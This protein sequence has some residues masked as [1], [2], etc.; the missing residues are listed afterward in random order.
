MITG[1]QVEKTTRR[2]APDLLIADSAKVVPVALGSKARLVTRRAPS[3]ATRVLAMAGSIAV[4]VRLREACAGAVPLLVVVALNVPEGVASGE[5]SRALA[6]STGSLFEATLE[7]SC[8]LPVAGAIATSIAATETAAIA[9]ETTTVAGSTDGTN[10]SD[11]DAS[12]GDTS[13]WSD[14]SSIHARATIASDQA[15]TAFYLFIL[16]SSL[17]VFLGFFGKGKTRYDGEH[18]KAQELRMDRMTR[19]H[20]SVLADFFEVSL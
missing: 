18:S 1:D 6:V 3:E 7:A 4:R 17:L 19:V 2:D 15:T 8:T 14:P 13:D 11:G 16:A 9:T 12:D 20:I 5:A 10:A